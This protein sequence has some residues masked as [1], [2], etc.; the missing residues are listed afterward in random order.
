MKNNKSKKYKLEELVQNTDFEAQ[1][2]DPVLQEWMNAKPVGRER[3][4]EDIEMPE[5]ETIEEKRAWIK[6]HYGSS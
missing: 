3:L 5:F 1:R 2:N 4:D 6:K